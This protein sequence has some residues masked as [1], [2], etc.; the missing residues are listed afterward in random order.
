VCSSSGNSA[1]TTAVSSQR[2]SRHGTPARSSQHRGVVS[3]P[4]V[5]SQQR[6]QDAASL[7]RTRVFNLC[8]ALVAFSS[9]RSATF[10]VLDFTDVALGPCA[11]QPPG[12]VDTLGHCLD[13][14]R[15]LQRLT[16]SGCRLD[17][18]AMEILLPRISS[19]LPRLQELLLSRNA[20]H[21]HR[22]LAK[23]LNTRS[24]MQRRQRAVPLSVLDLSG[25]PALGAVA[26]RPKPSAHRCV[27]EAIKRPKY[28]REA[29]VRVISDALRGG[30]QLRGLLLQNMELTCYDLKP[31]LQLL[32]AAVKRLQITGGHP[33]VSIR[34]VRLE[35]N[36]LD[37]D[38]TE[39]MYHALLWLTV[40]G[41]ESVATANAGYPAASK[42]ERAMS[43]PLLDDSEDFDSSDDCGP[44]LRSALSEGDIP[45]MDESEDAEGEALQVQSNPEQR[46]AKRFEFENDMEVLRRKL[47]H[48]NLEQN[49]PFSGSSTYIP[50]FR[51][52]ETTEFG[53][54]GDVEFVSPPWVGLADP[55]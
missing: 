4:V 37:A 33:S 48:Q 1:T 44:P 17:D 14:A 50:S 2:S 28:S 49:R 12:A 32:N 26:L 29:L 35:D 52:R 18:A 46:Q 51:D 10:R 47:S 38:F 8:T 41:S 19:R 9:I 39:V 7:E 16:L 5:V 36:P 22:L 3:K 11:G 42:I 13:M 31:L 15:G 30:L 27:A 54:A 20:L 6:M 34:A 25:N 45:S 43:L 24:S 53:Y 23:F 21:D 40:A 55:L